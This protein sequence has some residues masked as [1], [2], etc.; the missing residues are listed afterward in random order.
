MIEKIYVF[1]DVIDL[2]YQ[3]KIKNKLL[4]EEKFPWYYIDDISGDDPER[5]KRGGFTH[6]YVNEYGIES[7]YHYLFIDLIKKSCSKIKIKEVNAI[8]GRSFFQLPTNIKREDVDTPHT[9]IPVEHF[10]MLYYVC[11]SDGDTIIY[12]EKCKNYKNF[13][14]N[15]DVVDKTKF[16]IQKKVSPKQGRVVL[17]NGALYHTAEQPNHNV[18]CIVNYDLRDL[19]VGSHI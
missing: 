14:N 18:R 3:N 17:F 7:D 8:L 6:G 11:D 1:D 10:V 19:S 5:Q 13:D 12:N 4:G 9:D 15:Y 16:T 2:E